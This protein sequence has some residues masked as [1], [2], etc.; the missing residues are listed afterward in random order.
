MALLRR[1]RESSSAGIM[2]FVNDE[3]RCSFNVSLDFI[4]SEMKAAIPAMVNEFLDND[5]SL[6]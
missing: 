2:D 4:I 1:P 5:T 6:A 3:I